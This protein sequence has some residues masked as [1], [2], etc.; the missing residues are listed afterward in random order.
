VNAYE[1]MIKQKMPDKLVDLSRLFV[2]YNTRYLEGTVDVDS[3]A[4]MR[5]AMK[6][7]KKYGICTEELWPYIPSKFNVKPSSDCYIDARARNI[8]NYRLLSNIDHMMDALNTERPVV[9]GMTVYQG[10]LYVDKFNPVVRIPYS[11]E[12]GIGGH[13]M[14]LVGYDKSTEMF[15]AKNSFG[16]DWGDDGYCYIPFEYARNELYDCWVFDIVMS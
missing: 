4:F 1:M 9:F 2:Y 10:F 8:T 14:V 12:P 3:G 5:D 15:I 6:A 11:T 7:V 16:K 13:A